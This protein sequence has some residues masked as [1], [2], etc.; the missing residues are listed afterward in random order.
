M[1]KSEIFYSKFYEKVGVILA[2]STLFLFG[3]LSFSS[4][5]TTVLTTEFNLDFL[6]VRYTTYVG[7]NQNEKATK[8][9]LLNHI[10]P[11]CAQS[12]VTDLLN[13]CYCSCSCY[14]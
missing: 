2:G 6:H 11:H 9:Y 12:I 14:P 8:S 1:E 4:K 5:I 13:L 7:G 10:P 3:I